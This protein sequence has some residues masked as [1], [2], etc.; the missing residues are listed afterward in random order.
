MNEANLPLARYRLVCRAE[1]NI[2]LPAYSGSAW[3]GL[4]GH[5]LKKAVCVTREPSCEPCM[6][7]RNCVYSYVFETPPPSDTEVM[8]KYPSVPHPYVL[9]P[10]PEQATLVKQGDTLSV[11]L[12]LLGKA[13]QHLPY[14]LHSF[15]QAGERGLSASQGRF[16]VM[17]LA[18]QHQADWQTIYEAGGVLKALPPAVAAT[19]PCPEG[20]VTL[21]FV[22]PLRMRLQNREVTAATFSFYALFSVLMR[23]VSMLQTFH[24]DKPLVLDFKG[25]SAAAR[26]VS[27]LSNSLRWQDWSRYSSR[28]KTPVKMGGLVGEIT[29]EGASLAPFWALLY[30]GQSVHVGKG[31]VMGLGHYQIS[32]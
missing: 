7:Y 23:R 11:Y 10:E 8:R 26:E 6:L 5:A 17:A 2:N 12:T 32:Y 1:D 22:T 25:L 27:V 28:Q 21:R 24:T 20:V 15:E 19:P 14:L 16:K 3:R 13:N 29:L 18:Q 31:A 4:F 9:M 30:L